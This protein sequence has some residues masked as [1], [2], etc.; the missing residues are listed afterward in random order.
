MNYINPIM[1]Y[2]MQGFGDYIQSDIADALRSSHDITIKTLVQTATHRWIIRR[3]TP[4]ECTRLQGY[5]DDW[6]DLPGASDT[7]KYTALGNSIALPPWRYVLGRLCGQMERARQRE[8]HPGHR[9]H[10]A[11]LGSLF[12]GIGGFPLIWEE[13]NGKGSARWASEI[14]EFC[15]RVTKARFGEEVASP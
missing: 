9:A 13:I 12:D 5:P 2:A 14:N 3:L 4:L 8:A 6:L 15:I 7:A 11:T 1:T 10:T